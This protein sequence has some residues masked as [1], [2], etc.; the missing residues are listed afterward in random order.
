M[1]QYDFTTPKRSPMGIAA[2]DTRNDQQQ[3]L[4]LRIFQ[5]C[6]SVSAINNGKRS[7]MNNLI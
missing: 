6:N 1:L 7:K 3:I 5:T 4:T 2:K